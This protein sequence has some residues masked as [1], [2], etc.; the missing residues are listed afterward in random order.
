LSKQAGIA[1]WVFALWG[2]VFSRDRDSDQA[3]PITPSSTS[4]QPD[5]WSDW[6]GFANGVLEEKRLVFWAGAIGPPEMGMITLS[7]ETQ[8]RNASSEVPHGTILRLMVTPDGRSSEIAQFCER[9]AALIPQVSITREDGAELEY[10]WILLPN[11]VRYQGVPKGNEVLPFIQALTGKIPALPERLRDRLTAAPYPPAELDLF[12]TPQ[13][14]FCPRAVRGLMPLAGANRSIRLTIIDAGFFPEL[15]RRHGIQAVPTLVLDGQFRWAGSFVLEEVITLLTTRDPISMGPA[16][17]EMMLKE[18]AAQRLARMMADRNAVFPALLELLC[19]SQ[20]P[21]RLGAMVAVEELSAINPALGLQA[22]DAIW[23]RF[24]RVSD[25][26]KGDILFLCG[27]VG[28]SSVALRIKAV[29]QS[30]AS[31]EV[32]EAAE[33]ALEKLESLG[34]AGCVSPIA[35]PDRTEWPIDSVQPAPETNKKTPDS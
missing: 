27:E 32:K 20:W 9:M 35:M 12:V 19:H 31:A 11:G 17:I 33:E 30:G 24:G 10:P 29:L 25:P 15:S 28:G 26:V 6:I 3:Y 4:R 16:S 8:F 2:A 14:T 34:Q 13:C 1:G 5:Q 23:N 18:G 7:E 21:V 22:I